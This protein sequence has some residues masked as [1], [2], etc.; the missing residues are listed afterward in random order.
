MET[1]P[2][3]GLL[4]WALMYLPW[5]R[6]S[7]VH[8][9]TVGESHSKAGNGD[10]RRSRSNVSMVPRHSTVSTGIVQMTHLGELEEQV[11]PLEYP[12]YDLVCRLRTVAADVF[13]D[14]P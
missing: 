1:W 14:L 6:V 9:T 4:R 5:P 10:V 3:R 7:A 11:G 13:V 8:R 2:Y 12:T